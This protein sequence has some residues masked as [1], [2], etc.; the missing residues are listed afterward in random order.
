LGGGAVLELSHELDYARWLMGEVSGVTARVAHL[1]DLDIS[2]ED[3]AEIVLRFENGA[4]GS[5]H[6][7][8]LQR[9]PTR[10]CRIIGTEGTLT[11]DWSTHGVRCFSAAANEW[12]DLVPAQN[13]DRNDMYVAELKHFVD[14]IKGE[15]VSLCTG[16]DGRRD[17]EIAAAVKESSATERFIHL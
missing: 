12:E 6:L 8:M 9:S 2:V 13:L 5:V 15:S 11:W 1:S 7:D 14:C 4:L 17:L 3:L 10:S 16:E